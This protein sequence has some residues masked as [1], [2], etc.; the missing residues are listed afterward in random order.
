IDIQLAVALRPKNLSALNWRRHFLEPDGPRGRLLLVIP[1][2]EL[3]SR[4]QD[5]IAEIPI[6]VAQRL[7]WYRRT[8]LPRLGAE[9]NGD[10]FVTAKAIRKNQRTV[11]KQ[12]LDTAKRRLGV[13]MTAHQYRQLLG[14]S[15]LEAYPHDTETARLLLGHAWTKT[16]RIYVGSGT[17]RASRA[18][19]DFL[20][21]QRERLKLRRKRQLRRKPKVNVKQ[22][23]QSSKDDR[24]EP[25]CAD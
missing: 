25:P 16:T 1:A 13:H 5:F 11:T 18:Y 17:R 12:I 3:K 19:N 6:E 7:R 10:L 14:T 23:K 9:P 15:Y 24:G 20:L 2:A 8:I 4:K 22:V 21:E